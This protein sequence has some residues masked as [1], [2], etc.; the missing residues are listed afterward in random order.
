MAS[1]GVSQ[2]RA[3]VWV[4]KPGIGTRTGQG[5]ASRYED[6]PGPGPLCVAPRWL[7]RSKYCH[8]GAVLNEKWIRRRGSLSAPG[9]DQLANVEERTTDLVAW[10]RSSALALPLR[11]LENSDKLDANRGRAVVRASI[12][13][14]KNS[15]R[16][17]RSTEGDHWCST[18]SAANALAK[19]RRMATTGRSEA[20]S[21]SRTSSPLHSIEL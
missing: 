21:I 6:H 4:P 10:T 1:P 7:P 9:S 15:D 8:R 13:P 12:P 5:Q 17:P 2:L 19:I 18:A 20:T 14:E 3:H 11:A 16:A